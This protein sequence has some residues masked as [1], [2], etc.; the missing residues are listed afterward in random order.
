MAFIDRVVQYPGRV[1]LTP[2][3]GQPNVYDMRQQEGTVHTQGTQLN[4]NNL[5]KQ[6]QL[7]SSVASLFSAIQT[8]T[9]QNEM[10]SALNAVYERLKLFDQQLEMSVNPW[11]SGSCTVVG[12]NKYRMF[13]GVVNSGGSSFPMLIVRLNTALIGDVIYT[14]TTA[15]SYNQYSMS[16][17]AT[18]SGDVWT[19]QAARQI[20]HVGTGNHGGG[21]DLTVTSIRGMIP[22][23]F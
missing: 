23:G 16:L 7:D 5:N 17:R 12:S 10:S 1:S 3:S 4:A 8:S 9:K 19:M 15:G 11:T 2:V 18:I 14:N 22:F 6:T 21:L 13:M 20:T